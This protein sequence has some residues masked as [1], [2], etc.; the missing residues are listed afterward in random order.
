MKWTLSR[1]RENSF[2]LTFFCIYVFFLIKC[3]YFLNRC[4]CLPS[5][6][7]VATN[8][9]LLCLSRMRV[10]TLTLAW[11]ETLV[12]SHWLWTCSNKSFLF[13]SLTLWRTLSDCL[14]RLARV[15][16]SRWKLMKTLVL[17]CSSPGF[18]I[19]IRF[20]CF[21]LSFSNLVGYRHDNYLYDWQLYK[22]AIIYF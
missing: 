15:D 3:M 12:H 14:S 4:T 9:L 16:D 5:K 20:V 18:T 17:V 7:F 8:W 21:L 13:H 10:K 2:L 6:S 1:C 11:P 19:L 22:N